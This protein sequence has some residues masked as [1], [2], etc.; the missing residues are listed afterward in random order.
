MSTPKTFSALLLGG[1]PWSRTSIPQEALPFGDGT[2]L[3]RVIA[4]YRD[5]GA[6]KLVLALGPQEPSLELAADPHRSTA[7]VVRVSG[8]RRG[9][10]NYLVA[11]LEALDASGGAIAIGLCDMALLTPELVETLWR[12]YREAGRPLGVPLCQGVLGHPLFVSPELQDEL[13]AQHGRRTH[14]DLLLAHP[15]DVTVLPTDYT[16]VLRSIED[17]GDYQEM[18]EIAGLPPTDLRAYRESLRERLGTGGP[19]SDPT[20]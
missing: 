9:L 7:D 8:E 10:G 15:D 6:Q 5:A 13:I 19:A 14:R 4:A 16:A 2:V 12:A 3:D 18:L 1:F 11:G 20:G 17:L